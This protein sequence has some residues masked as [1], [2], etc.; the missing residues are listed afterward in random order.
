MNYEKGE[1]IILDNDK[2]YIVLDFFEMDNKKYIF[3]IGEAEKDLAL[4]EAINDEF[5]D[6]ESDEEHE[7]VFNLLFQRNKEEIYKAMKKD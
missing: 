5:K 3:L 1:A 7:K 4:V 2:E 6:I